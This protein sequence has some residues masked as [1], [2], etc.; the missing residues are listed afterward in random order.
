MIAAVSDPPSAATLPSTSP[1]ASPRQPACTTASAGAPIVVAIAIGTQSAASASTGCPGSSVQSASPVSRSAGSRAMHQRGV[2][3][4]VDGEPLGVEPELGAD[5]PA[6]LDDPGLVVA[7]A[8]E[9]ER[10][11]GARAHPALAR[12]E[13]DDVRPGRVPADHER[14]SSPARASSHSLRLRL[15]S[16][17]TSSSSVC[18]ALPSSGPGR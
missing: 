8:A 17:T 15:G 1:A 13:R 7:A 11:V 10:G 16:S 4:P 6:I 12:G 14:R 5:D 3:L 2:A 18:K 9:V